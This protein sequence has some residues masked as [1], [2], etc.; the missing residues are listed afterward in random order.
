MSY[1]TIN[2]IKLGDLKKLTQRFLDNVLIKSGGGCWEWTGKISKGDYGMFSINKK[3]KI[4]HRVAYE[5]TI[6]PIPE[7]AFICHHCD[8]R[9]CVNT[10]HLFVGDHQANMDDMAAK[11]RRSS[12]IG[13]SNGNAKLTAEQ[14]QEIRGLYVPRKFG[15]KKIAEMYGVHLSTI[16][17]V[18][19]GKNWPQRTS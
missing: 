10:A 9:S 1:Q 15:Y 13:E 14:V 4:A 18:V 11:N 3:W 7:G 12:Q 8:N 5:L 6:G 17:S 2:D 16:H 19:T